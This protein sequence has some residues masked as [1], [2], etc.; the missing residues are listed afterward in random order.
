M[1]SE[2]VTLTDDPFMEGN[3]HQMPF[4]GEGVP[5]Y[6]KAVVENG[7]FKT[8]LY[9]LKS[10]EMAETVTTGN[11]A[12]Q[13]SNIGTK[14][15]N[16]RLE[17]GEYSREELFAKAGDG[18]IFV[19][20]MKG[21]HA[22]ANAVT[23]DFSIE[24]AGFLIEDGKIGAPI[25]SFTVAGNFFELLRQITDIDNVLEMKSPGFSQIGSPDV[26]VPDMSVAG[27]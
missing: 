5:T 21:F 24:S 11:A 9:N 16:F 8:F 22:G 10:A 2:K 4:D 20:E 23:G 12:R 3:S 15:Y 19:T 25:K 26:L 13:G 17:P 6:T 14:V 18:S 27:E 1:A 7:V